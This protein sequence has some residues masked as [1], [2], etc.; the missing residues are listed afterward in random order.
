MLLET[1]EESGDAGADENEGTD[2]RRRQLGLR[3]LFSGRSN[4][5][6]TEVV[7]PASL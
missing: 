2:R 5:T 7:A 6:A 4:A 1:E 3:V